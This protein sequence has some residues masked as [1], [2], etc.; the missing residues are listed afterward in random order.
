MK[1]C[2]VFYSHFIQFFGAASEEHLAVSL[3]R[4]PVNLR[5]SASNCMRRLWSF[6]TALT[7]D[8]K[9]DIEDNV[10]PLF[11]LLIEKSLFLEIQGRFVLINLKFQVTAS[12][13][14]WVWFHSLLGFAGRAANDKMRDNF[15]C[16]LMEW[17]NAQ[18][19]AIIN[20]LTLHPAVI[21]DVV[22]YL[23]AQKGNFKWL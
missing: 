3:P 21:S 17:L 11:V 7:H 1:F 10:L 23:L 4:S 2:F 5:V 18:W 13:L 12:S 6:L 9:A 8:I 19:L 22:L 16:F 20:H 15:V 14:G